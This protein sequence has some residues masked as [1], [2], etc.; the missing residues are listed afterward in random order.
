M[1]K[2]K[3]ANGNKPLTDKQK[4]KMIQDA[5]QHYGNYMTALG[6]N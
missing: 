6:F 5:A 1:S 3:Y 2:L 4:Q